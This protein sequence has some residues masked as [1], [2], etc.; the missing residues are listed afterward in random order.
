MAHC[1][2]IK[3]FE[4]CSF[5]LCAS[6]FHSVAVYF[7]ALMN[8]ICVSP[9]HT[10]GIFLLECIFNAFSNDNKVFSACFSLFL[11]TSLAVIFF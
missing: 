3:V 4:N 1:K 5:L 6:S 8:T 11:I 2:V 9:K 7:F 10:Y